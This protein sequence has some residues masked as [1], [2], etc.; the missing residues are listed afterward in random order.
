MTKKLKYPFCNLKPLLP[1]LLLQI[2][3]FG[4]SPEKNLEALFLKEVIR[5]EGI[6]YAGDR[7][8]GIYPDRETANQVVQSY[9]SR[10]KNTKYELTY[11]S[12]HPSFIETAKG[13]DVFARFAQTCPKG[14]KLLTKEEYNA[15]T[16]MAKD[17]TD[18]AVWYY[19]KTKK[20]KEENARNH[21]KSLF[22]T[23]K[24]Y[25]MQ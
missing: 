3:C 2:S 10:N 1:F 25:V 14:Y 13:E 17:K 11:K 7:V 4:Q 18:A 16:I 20:E 12:I 5:F 6:T 15:I 23:Y 19:M 22:T 24:K 8:F 21:I 9:M